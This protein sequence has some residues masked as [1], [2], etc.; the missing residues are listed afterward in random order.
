MTEVYS[1]D[2]VSAGDYFIDYQN[3]YTHLG[4]MSLRTLFVTSAEAFMRAG[5]NDRALEM[6]DRCEQVMAHYPI[7][8]I[9]LGFS[10]NDYMVVSA[11]QDYYRL[12]QP[13]K[14]RALADRLAPELL[15]TA[16]F[17]LDFYDWGVSEFEMAGSYIYMLSDVL[18]SNGEAESAD[19]LIDEF[20]DMIET[21][22]GQRP[23]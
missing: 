16:S 13:E 9:P 1:F 20:A 21:S 12:G 17:Y 4:V 15:H 23:S 7:E 14:A 2:A 5:E 22:T 11:V 3:H 18:R 8:A 10:G 6:L 19:A